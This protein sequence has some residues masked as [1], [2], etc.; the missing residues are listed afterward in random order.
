M[1]PDM[2][3]PAMWW[4]S[5]IEVPALVGLFA[6]ILNVMRDLA[7][8][9]LFVTQNFASFAQTRELE[10]R[11]T[12]HLLRIEAKLDTTALKTERLSARNAFIKPQ[13][14]G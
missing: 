4:I 2:I 14:R 9:R 3:G 11:L 8:F 6:L 1:T 5:V 7:N 12:A 13:T 10:Q